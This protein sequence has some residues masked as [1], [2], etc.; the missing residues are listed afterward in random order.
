VG[1]DGERKNQTIGK[2]VGRWKDGKREIVKY[3][4]YTLKTTHG[5]KPTTGATNGAAQTQTD[6][7]KTHFVQ[8]RGTE[9]KR[10]QKKNRGNPCILMNQGKIMGKIRKDRKKKKK[11]DQWKAHYCWSG[12]CLRTPKCY[13]FWREMW[14]VKKGEGNKTK[15]NPELRVRGWTLTAAVRLDQWR[16]NSNYQMGDS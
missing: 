13:T 15:R 2:R 14:I 7:E 6:P 1:G 8:G 10:N 9:K 5:E 11:K 16:N 12:R 4:Q 3:F